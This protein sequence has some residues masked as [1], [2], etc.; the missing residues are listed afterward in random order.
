M[1]NL[2]KNHKDECG[3]FHDSLEALQLSAEF[4]IDRLQVLAELPVT[5]RRHA[6]SCSACMQAVDDLARVRT[7]LLPLA[8]ESAATAPGPWFSIKVLNA[9]S[10][11]QAE[12]NS[13]EAVWLN[14]RRL[15]PRLS[16]FCALLL[17]FAGAWAF[18]VQQQVAASQLL[19]PAESLFESSPSAPLNDDV[20]AGVEGRR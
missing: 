15:A 9:I 13:R 10:A 14:V 8:R 7:I 3:P 17:L 4:E 5:D 6:E 2:G 1:L 18:Q 16:A 19:R 11:Q 12:A 20:L